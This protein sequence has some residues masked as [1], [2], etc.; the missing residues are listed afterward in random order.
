MLRNPTSKRTHPKPKAVLRLPDFGPSEICRSE[1]SDLSAHALLPRNHR[2]HI[3]SNMLGRDKKK[4]SN[5]SS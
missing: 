2:R 1:Q 3:I 5:R 4:L